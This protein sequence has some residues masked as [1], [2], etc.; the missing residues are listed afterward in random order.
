MKPRAPS[1]GALARGLEDQ[2]FDFEAPETRGERLRFRAFQLFVLGY[3]VL[4]VWQWGLQIQHIPAVVVPHGVARHIDLSFFVGHRA[5]LLNAALITLLSLGSAW[6]R[7]ARYTLPALVLLLHWQYAARFS[8]GKVTHGAHYVGLALVALALAPFVTESA[9]ARRRFA[10]NA[11]LFFMGLGYVFAAISK[12]V[13]RG[14]SWPDGSHLWLWIEE[15]RLDQLA[16]LG[17]A[18]LNFVQELCLSSWALSTVCLAVG[19]LSEACGFLLWFPRTRP[20]IALALIGLHLGVLV[21]MDI[22]F[23]P[24]TLQVALLGL[25]WQRLVDRALALGAGPSLGVGETPGER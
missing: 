4:W 24:F 9:R 19:L 1:L 12:L 11:T 14:L 15:R 22:W 3:A 20:F 10:L 23:G 17:T 21:T 18:E 2:L 25:P 7:A 5:A 16:N 8:L 6:P 13:A